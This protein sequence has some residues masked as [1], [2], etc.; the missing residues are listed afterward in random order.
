MAGPPATRGP[1][2]TFHAW[3]QSRAH[4]HE[5]PPSV[6]MARSRRSARELRASVGLDGWVCSVPWGGKVPQRLRP[7][8]PPPSTWRGVFSRAV[9]LRRGHFP[10]VSLNPLS[11]QGADLSV[12]HWWGVLGGGRAPGGWPSPRAWDT[13]GPSTLRPPA[14]GAAPSLVALTQCRPHPCPF[15]KHSSNDSNQGCYLLPARRGLAGQRKRRE[16][17]PPGTP[18]LRGARPR[19][20][21]AAL[22]LVACPLSLPQRNPALRSSLPSAGTGLYVLTPERLGPSRGAGANSDS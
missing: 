4:P 21:P 3:R 1:S 15:I 16:G 12:L 7:A 14:P 6:G 8:S 10:C 2:T 9:L 13:L 19:G 17:E 20:W 18:C 5:T 22:C 11:A